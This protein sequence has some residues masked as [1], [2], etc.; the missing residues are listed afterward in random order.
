MGSWQLIDVS[1]TL[2]S[3]FFWLIETG[4]KKQ[5]GMKKAHVEPTDAI[6]PKANRKK[7]EVWS[8]KER[9]ESIIVRTFEMSTV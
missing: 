9:R 5:E 4:H 7:Y 8:E 6:Y 3:S 2:V 1:T